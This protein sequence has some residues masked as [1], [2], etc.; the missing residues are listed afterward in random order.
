M[1]RGLID[2]HQPAVAAGWDWEPSGGTAHY[3][4]MATN[5]VCDFYVPDAADPNEWVNKGGGD[6][7]VS[8]TAVWHMFD[9]N[10]G[11]DVGPKAEG[12]Y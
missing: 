5:M 6:P 2:A 11:I 8:G 10:A 12:P 7:G 3:N 9:V 1:L 4:G